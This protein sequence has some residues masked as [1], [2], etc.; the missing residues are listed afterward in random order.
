MKR[1]LFLF[2]AFMSLLAGIASARTV[3]GTVTEAATGEPVLGASVVVKGNQKVGTS[4]DIDGKFTLDVPDNAKTLVVSYIGMQPEEVKIQDNMEIKLIE[5]ASNLDEIVVVGYST[6]TKR[7][8]ISSVSTVKSDQI[9][10]L[11]VTNVIQGMAGRSPGVLIQA[12][13]G[14]INSRPSVSIRGG[15]T[16]LYVIDG[17]IRSEDDFANLAPDDIKDVSILKD[18]SATAVYGSRAANGIIQVTTKGGTSGSIS[19]GRAT[20]EYDF[21]ASWAQ[22]NIWPEKMQGYDRAVWYNK[23]R[24]NDGLDPYWSDE[25]IQAMRDGSDPEHYS[26]T[27]WRKLVLRNWAPQTKHALR[28]TGGNEMNQFYL[29][30]AHTDQQSLYRSDNHWMK[31]TNFRITDNI[32]LKEYGLHINATID[33]YH[34]KQTHPYTST[35]SSYYQVFSH[36]NNQKPYRPGYNNFGLPFSGIT[37]NPV[38]ETADDAGYKLNKWNVINGKGD[39]I[40]DCLWVEGLKLRYSANYR[41][42]SNTQ[43][44]WRKDAAAYAWDSEMPTYANKPLLYHAAQSGYGFT[45][46]VFVEYNRKFGKHSVSALAGYENYYEWGE[47]YWEQR[48]NYDF[49]ID[50]IE[51]GP[52]E[53]VTNGGSEAELGRAAW[54]FQAKYSYDGRYLVEGSLRRDGSDRFAP[55]KRWGNFYSGSLGWRITQEKFMEDIVERNIFNNLKLRASYGETG[56]DSSAGRFQY[57]TSYEPNNLGYVV[58]GKYVPTFSEGAIA[59]PDLTWYTTKQT[60]IGLDFASLNSRLWGSIDYFYYSTKGYLV[61]P[62][63]DSYINNVIGI[64]LPRVKSDSEFRREGWE[65]QLGWRDKAGDFTYDISGNF[66]LYNSLWARIADEAESS[67]M[68]PYTRQQQ[69][70]QNYYGNIYHVLGFYQ[71]A[72]DIINNPGFVSAINSGNMTAGDLMYEDTN[73]DGQITSADGRLRGHQSAPKGQYGINMSFGYKGFYLTMLFQGSTAFDMYVPGEL[74]LQ[75]GQSTDMPVMFDFQTDVWTP[76]NRNA[77]LPRLMSNTGSNANQ[78]YVSS[79][80]W[81]VN[82]QY[83]RMKDLQFGYDFKYKLLRNLKWISRC[84]LGFSGQ[85]LFT[86]S[87]AKKYGMDP[88]TASTSNYGYPVERVLAVTLNLGF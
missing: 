78:N 8:L 23:A 21:N 87:K 69:R 76:D 27:D 1:R 48:E 84:R 62:T 51:I 33:G 10:N 7:D 12:S 28:L 5:S 34:Q 63:G 44:E 6:S 42:Y 88:E 38:V 2:M 80:F 68:N 50:Q 57:L 53:G 65:F 22:P 82:G 79:D 9:T 35:A 37:D 32:Y 81:L 72:A 17:I 18:A 29:S 31:R 39:L 26:N 24:A 86:I 25:A 47:N 56:L 11:P 19:Q 30:L 4:T 74:G 70:K 52:Q 20:I 3:R 13:G 73:G 54:I 15:G 67:Y 59:S 85:N 61:A 64:G 36:I 16:P 71:S 46:Q 43:K 14:G 49:P 77:M 58:G 45:N 40:W 55:G 66:T 60:D 41:Y 75:T 83:L